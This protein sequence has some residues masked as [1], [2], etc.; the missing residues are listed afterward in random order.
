MKLHPLILSIFLLVSY[1][2]Q[3]QVITAV[4]YDM[5]GMSLHVWSQE[6]MMSTR[7]SEILIEAF[8]A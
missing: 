6:T 7:A 4:P 8:A 2:N 1:V 5:L 3:A